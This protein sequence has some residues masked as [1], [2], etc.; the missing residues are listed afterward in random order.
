LYEYEFNVCGKHDITVLK[1]WIKNT[2]YKFRNNFHFYVQE[3]LITELITPKLHKDF[4]NQGTLMYALCGLYRVYPEVK[5]VSV[6][7]A[8]LQ[9]IFLIKGN[10]PDFK[11][12]ENLKLNSILSFRSYTI[13][14]IL[15]VFY[16]CRW[17]PEHKK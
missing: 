2:D 11:I 9:Q 1:V 6:Y 10:L 5:K 8:K 7:L 3:Q 15:Q 12:W 14:T 17:M 16:R 4:Q 13:V